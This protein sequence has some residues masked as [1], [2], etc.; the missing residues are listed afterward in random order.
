MYPRRGSVVRPLLECRRAE[1]RA[2]LVDQQLPY[3]E[4][5][6]N[7]DVGIP[8][9]RVRAELLPLLAG[10]FNPGI[11]DALAREAELARETWA[12]LEQEAA[13]FEQPTASPVPPASPAPP[14]RPA[15]PAPRV[16]ELDIERLATAPPPLRRL[17]LW[18]A[19]T[20]VSGGRAVSFRHVDAAVDLLG[21]DGQVM[22]APGQRVQRLGARLVL[23]GRPE[24]AVGRLVPAPVRQFEYPLSVPGE[25]E[26]AE[27]GCTVSV[28]AAPAGPARSLDEQLGL[29]PSAVVRGDRCVGTLTVR[30]RRPG[31]RFRPIGLGGGKKLQ[32]HFVDRKTAR[33]ERDRVPIVVDGTG[34]IVWVAGH[35]IDETFR[36]TDASQ[37]VLLLRLKLLGGR[38]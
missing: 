24:G 36:V 25:V 37:S 4:D 1:L 16:L 13:R 26:L 22:D 9:N 20:S 27:A 6:T 10:R 12:W 35:G 17:V 28:E 23:T 7:S 3:V 21:V 34:R 5:S 2:F 29:G 15:A 32:D 31:D 30:N 11:V 33:A 19:M 18:R 38:A 14:G 8:R